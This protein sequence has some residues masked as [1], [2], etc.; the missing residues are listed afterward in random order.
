MSTQWTSMAIE[1]DTDIIAISSA[2]RVQEI[3]SIKSESLVGPSEGIQTTVMRTENGYL[4]KWYVRLDNE[5]VLTGEAPSIYS[6]EEESARQALRAAIVSLKGDEPEVNRDM[7]H[8]GSDRH[9]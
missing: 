5:Q 1:V 9:A 8:D 6:T 4:G 7:K 2:R 3:W